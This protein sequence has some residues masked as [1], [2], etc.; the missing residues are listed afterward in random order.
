M[1]R[2]A[3]RTALGPWLWR[4]MFMFAALC[5]VPPHTI[6][7][8]APPACTP[9]VARIVSIEGTVAIRRSGQANWSAVTRLDMPMCEGDLLHAGARS[10]AAV[11]ILREKFVR[12]DQNSTVSIGVSGDETV[13]EFFQDETTPRDAC[14][15]GYFITRFPRKFKVRIPFVYAAVEGAEFMVRMSCSAAVVAVFEGK[16]SAETLLANAQRFI[17]SSGESIAAG[18]GE[19]P[20]VKL[21]VKP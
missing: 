16:V 21:V 6:A 11:V 14:G 7:A 5:A 18:P 20:V 12:L 10:R 17:L 4:G 13:V 3:R 8:E 19:P 9:V 15:A 2:W 1:R